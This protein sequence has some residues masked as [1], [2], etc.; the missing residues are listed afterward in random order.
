M[1]Q[2][3][4]FSSKD[5]ANLAAKKLGGTVSPSGALFRVRLGPFASEAAA[6]TAVNQAAAKGYPGGRIMAND[7]P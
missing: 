4:A 1:V 2:V 7:G 3:A 5:R 6:R